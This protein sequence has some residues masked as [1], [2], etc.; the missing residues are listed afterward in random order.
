V[1]RLLVLFH[2]PY[3]L[4]EGEARAWL[5]REVDAL[6]RHDELGEA[7]LTRL[8][9]ATSQ[10]RGGFDW[11]LEFSIDRAAANPGHLI[12]ELVADLRLLGMRPTV[13]VADDRNA[14]ELKR[15]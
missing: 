12:G 9:S 1:P 13:A 14:T 15:R 5:R 11:L 8:G 4:D 10:P 7:R 2:D 6:L 3:H